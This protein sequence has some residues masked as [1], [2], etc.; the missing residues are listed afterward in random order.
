M[1]NKKPTS[2]EIH[3]FEE[4]RARRILAYCFPSKYREAE[5]SESPDI[6]VPKLS[7]GVE[8]TKSM[9]PHVMQNLERASSITG[10]RKEDL[11]EVNKKNIQKGLVQARE[12]Q[13][14]R[15]L[16][17]FTEWGATHSIENIYSRKTEKLNAPHFQKFDTNN[18]FICAWLID[19]DELE[20][21]IEYILSN[22]YQYTGLL[23]N[24]IVYII[25]EQKLFYIQDD[26]IHSIDISSETLNKIGHES[27][28]EIMGMTREEYYY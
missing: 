3:K 19:Q 26:S 11:S 13:D 22:P 9:L 5:L 10:K 20:G 18:L 27:F 16:A 14:G 2:L 28:F 21:G 23:C 12:I 1:N 6:I 8:V 4:E 15:Y 25:T 17:S 7:I 24:D